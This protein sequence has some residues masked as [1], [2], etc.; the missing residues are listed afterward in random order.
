M[1][2]W[3][4][5]QRSLD[6]NEIEPLNEIQKRCVKRV[7]SPPIEEREEENE[8]FTMDEQIES[9]PSI[10]SIPDEIPEL[11]EIN[12]NVA[13][14]QPTS[15]TKPRKQSNPIKVPPL[16]LSSP[17]VSPPQATSPPMN[18]PPRVQFSPPSTPIKSPPKKR[19]SEMKN[20][21]KMSPR[22]N[23]HATI[24]KQ[25]SKEPVRK[26]QGSIVP[27]A[28]TVPKRCSSF[29]L[30]NSVSKVNKTQTNKRKQ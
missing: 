20:K 24:T 9:T 15:P 23:R 4:L 10:P 3:H 22:K 5:R 8:I 28:F 6:E 29:L 18:S 21:L 1:S 17:T 16:S 26:S 12:S 14:S 19:V 11:N 25:A 7:M 13:Q 2:G 27:W 30:L